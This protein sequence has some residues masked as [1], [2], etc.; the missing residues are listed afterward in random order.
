MW[1]PP[2]SFMIDYFDAEVQI[3]VMSID[4]LEKVSDHKGLHF[5]SYLFVSLILVVWMH[6]QILLLLFLSQECHRG[7]N[8]FVT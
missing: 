5:N 8:F 7:N 3:C 6:F 2:I 1:R 4:T